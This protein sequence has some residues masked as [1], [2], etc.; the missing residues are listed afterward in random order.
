MIRCSVF[1]KGGTTV[2]LNQV[3]SGTYLVYLYV[4]EDNNP[5]VYALFVQNKEVIKAYNSGPAGHWDK[6]GPF[7]AVVTDSVLEVH[8]VGGDANFSGLEVWRLGK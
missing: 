6:L 2:K 5:E 8:S 3:P 1:G 4:W 7:T